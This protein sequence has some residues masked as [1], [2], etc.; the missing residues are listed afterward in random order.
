VERLILAYHQ[1]VREAK[2]EHQLVLVGETLFRSRGIFETIAKLGLGD[3]IVL[4]GRH[5]HGE[6]PLFYSGA[7]V[8]AFPTLS[9]GFGLPPLEAM[10]CGTPVVASNVTSVPEVLGDAALMFDPSRPEEIAESILKT[11]TDDDL[12]NELVRRGKANSAKYSWVET[13]RHIVSAY[14]TIHQAGW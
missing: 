10:A 4:P 3:R 12:R 5:P 8:F 2:I 1:L 9:E 6:L 7:D 13:A 14:E 11:L